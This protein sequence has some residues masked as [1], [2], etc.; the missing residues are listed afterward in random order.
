MIGS[1]L[2]RTSTGRSSFETLLGGRTAITIRT[3]WLPASVFG[4][5][6]VNTT[7]SVAGSEFIVYQRDDGDEQ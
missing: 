4:I 1:T 2:V 5:G 6:K 7:E 3:A